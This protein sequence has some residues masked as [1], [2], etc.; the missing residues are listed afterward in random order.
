MYFRNR[1][2]CS[3]IRSCSA[4]FCGCNH[5]RVAACCL[6]DACKI[7]TSLM[8]IILVSSRFLCVFRVPAA[9]CLPYER[10]FDLCAFTNVQQIVPEF[11]E[12]TS[13]TRAL[14]FR[15]SILKAV[16]FSDDIPVSPFTSRMRFTLNKWMKIFI[17]FF[18][19]RARCLLTFHTKFFFLF[20]RCNAH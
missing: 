8:I 5:E 12:F 14:A 6:S 3:L 9:F 11:Y 4:T 16:C 7:L 20:L 15:W 1:Y 18:H 2:F 13:F 10:F 19:P 17:F